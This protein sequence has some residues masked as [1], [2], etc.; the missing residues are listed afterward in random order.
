MD[1]VTLT[2]LG[3]GNAHSRRF[4]NSSAVLAINAAH[5]VIDF[6]FTAYHEYKAR[7]NRYP[8]AI[9]ITHGHFDHIGGLENL[10]FD[11][12]F[13]HQYKIKLYV[14]HTLVSLLH[15]KM[16][17]V[18]HMIAEGGVGFWDAFQLIPVG[19]TFWFEDRLF[20]VFENRHHQPGFSFGLSLPGVFLYSGDTK[21]I[22]EIINHLASQG[23]IIFH[24]L[25]L[26]PQP[27]HTHIDEL[28]QY[29]KNVLSRCYFYHLSSEK[30]HL[31]C[32]EKG[33]K[34]VKPGDSFRFG[35]VTLD[36]VIGS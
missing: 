5:L 9:F 16:A 29:T 25:S 32:A 2:F 14:P 30:D 12:F 11:A 31:I 21:P 19:N 36:K 23:E 3:C 28:P 18:E 7:Y 17:S 15:Q 6:G 13:S 10:F 33:L 22:P 35:Q 24:D 8:D 34:L 27:S 1:D 26:F 4:G 20:K